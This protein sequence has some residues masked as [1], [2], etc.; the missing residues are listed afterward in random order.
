[1]LYALALIFVVRPV[2]VWLAMASSSADGQQRRLMAWMGMRGVGAFYYA[3]W[4][5]DR[6]GDLLGPVL[7]VALDAIVISVVVRGVTANYALSRYFRGRETG[8][9][10][11]AP[12]T[13]AQPGKRDCKGDV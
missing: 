12:H 2:A 5:I 3:V 10:D 7:P 13:G 1:M 4:G 8:A 6:A 11:Q 9:A